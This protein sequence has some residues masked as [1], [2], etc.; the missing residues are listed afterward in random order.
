MNVYVAVYQ[1]GRRKNGHFRYAFLALAGT[2]REALALA[3][4]AK[5]ITPTGLDGYDAVS[6]APNRAGVGQPDRT[7]ASGGARACARIR[8]LRY[9]AALSS[10]ASPAPSGALHGRADRRRAPAQT[11]GR[12]D[13]Q[14]AAA[15]RLLGRA[16]APVGAAQSGDA[17]STCGSRS[18]SRRRS[19]GGSCGSRRDARR[20]HRAGGGGR[21]PVPC[22]SGMSPLRREQPM[23]EALEKIPEGPRGH[24]RDSQGARRGLRRRRRPA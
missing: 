20:G 12:L 10:T 18:T 19:R 23:N 2:K 7:C 11:D 9:A 15:R 24:A 6:K 22:A 14:A 16:V 4:I 17:A 21:Q 1:E 3:K 8:V 5:G 13:H